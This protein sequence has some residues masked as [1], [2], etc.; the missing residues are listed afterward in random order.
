MPLK[1]TLGKNGVDDEPLGNRGVKHSLPIS[2]SSYPFLQAQLESLAVLLMVQ[3]NSSEIE[4]T[5]ILFYAKK[6]PTDKETK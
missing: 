2:R 1:F 3:T 4:F 6:L 5:E